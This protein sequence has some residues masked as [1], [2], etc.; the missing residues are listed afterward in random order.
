MI[1]LFVDD[2]IDD[3]EFFIDALSYVDPTI[4]CILGK[5]CEDAFSILQEASESPDYIFLDIHMPS[6]EDGKACLSKLKSDE[7]FRNVRVVM[8]SNTN[9]QLMMEEYKKLGATYFLVK[10]PTFKGLCDS[11][12]VLFDK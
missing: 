10:P 4:K 3:R 2:D 5:D 11:L 7:R 8:Y 1:V 12:S 6:N 9:D